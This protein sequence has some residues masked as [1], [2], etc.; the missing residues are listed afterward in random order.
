MAGHL[1]LN[2]TSHFRAIHRRSGANAR[3]SRRGGNPV[4]LARRFWIPACAGMTVKE[5]IE[6]LELDA[7]GIHAAEYLT[8]LP[9]P[10]M[11]HRKLHEAIETARARIETI[12]GDVG[13]EG[14][15]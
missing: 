12:E 8:V 14:A 4:V 13:Q 15:A 11:L 10:D 9:P 7:S 1:R 5:R 6:L 3:H 2:D